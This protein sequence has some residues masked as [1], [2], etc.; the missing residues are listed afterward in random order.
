MGWLKT[1]ILLRAGQ[2]FSMRTKGEVVLA[3]L[4]GSIYRPDG[5][6]KAVNTDSWVKPFSPKE[7]A[8]TDTIYDAPLYGQLV[9]RIGENSTKVV[10]AGVNYS[11]IAKTS[12]MLY[13]CIYESVFNSANTG[14]YITK[15]TIDKNK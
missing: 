2:H 9:F 15:I 7:E 6:Y 14:K 8:Y 5:S 1:G 11:G 10:K 3:S 13:L 4:S 12:G